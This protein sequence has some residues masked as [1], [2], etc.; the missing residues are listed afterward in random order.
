MSTTGACPPA[1]AELRLPTAPSSGLAP[2]ASSPRGAPAFPD[3]LRKLEERHLDNRLKMQALSR[4]MTQQADEY[5]RRLHDDLELSTR[6]DH[7]K[8]RLP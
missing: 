8:A 1:A 4:S 3:E 2:G 5:R 7:L 6:I